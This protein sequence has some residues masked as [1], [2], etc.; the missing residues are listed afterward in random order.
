MFQSCL[1]HFGFLKFQTFLHKEKN[2]KSGIPDFS[3][4]PSLASMHRKVWN[5]KARFLFEDTHSEIM[6]SL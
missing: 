5:F 6:G 1:P 4:V 2:G 3:T